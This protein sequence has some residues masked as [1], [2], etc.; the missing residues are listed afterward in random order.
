MG[1]DAG[2]E[3]DAGGVID[4]LLGKKLLEA[5]QEIA[6]AQFAQ[7]RVNHTL[8]PTAVVNEIW[9]R[10]LRSESEPPTN[11]EAFR[12]WAAKA[13][14][15]IL[16]S[17]ARGKN[18]LKRGGGRKPVALQAHHGAD[19]GAGVSLLELEEELVL[20]ENHNPR[21]AR[22]VELRFFGGMSHAEVGVELGISER[23]SQ[24]LWAM[25]RS[26]LS[27]RLRSA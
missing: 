12:V 5:M 22:V 4:P 21:A 16:I 9:V 3:H 14:R 19:I 20:L 6:S 7:E 11:I 13:V 25:A 27:I 17:H 15:N 18:A 23:L 10:I 26:W 8:Q 1:G 24:D 2:G